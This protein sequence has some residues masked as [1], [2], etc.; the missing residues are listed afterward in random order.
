MCKVDRVSQR[1][2]GMLRRYIQD[3]R[4]VMAETK[5]VLRVGG[6]AIFVIGNCSLRNEF[7][8]NSR[9]IEAPANE[10]GMVVTKR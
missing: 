2:A 9:C 7:V 4:Q 1:H 5:R 3:I 8:R 6:R 10:L